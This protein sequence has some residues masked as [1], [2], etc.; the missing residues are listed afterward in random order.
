MI[1]CF[2]V[3][4]K[5]FPVFCFFWIIYFIQFIL[6]YKWP[7]LFLLFHG[8]V[9]LLSHT[10]NTYHY[11]LVFG[12]I[13]AFLIYSKNICIWTTTIQTYLIQP[14]EQSINT[15][16]HKSTTLFWLFQTSLIPLKG[17]LK[18]TSVITF[19]STPI[20]ISFY[21]FHNAPDVWS[22]TFD[23]VKLNLIVR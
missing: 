23:D 9:Q 18:N 3:C 4:F 13:F 16:R 20:L 11:F 10:E 1:D 6:V 14:I 7:I 17:K 8:L 12:F 15:I 5:L 21:C 2:V 22:L 19:L